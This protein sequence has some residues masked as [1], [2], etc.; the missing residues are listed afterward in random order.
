MEK[1]DR[2]H[3]WQNNGT[4]LRALFSELR[5]K[6]IIEINHS[7][8]GAQRHH[9]QSAHIPKWNIIRLSEIE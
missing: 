2:G 5:S 9:C 3:A 4:A 7:S 1:N 6:V 8:N